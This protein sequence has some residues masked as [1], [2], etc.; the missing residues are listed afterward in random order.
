MFTED[1]AKSAA[2]RESTGGQLQWSVPWALSPDS[3]IWAVKDPVVDRLAEEYVDLQVAHEHQL[4]TALEKLVDTMAGLPEVATQRPPQVLG[5]LEQADGT[6]AARV[7][8]ALE[9]A[10][11]STADARASSAI[12]TADGSFV[13]TVPLVAR[14]SDT[15]V[16]L[17]VTSGTGVLRV[18]DA[19][20]EIRPSGVLPTTRLDGAA[21]PLPTDLVAA[22]QQV[23]DAAPTA[24]PVEPHSTPTIAVGEDECQLVFRKDS[25]SDRFP[26]GVLFRLTDPALSQPSMRYHLPHRDRDERGASLSYYG[27]FS[28]AARVA[29]AVSKLRFQLA[30]RVPVDRP[31]DI[32]A[33]REGLAVER[34]WGGIPVAGSLSIGYVVQMAQRWTPLGLALGDLVYSLPLAPGEQQRIAVTERTSTSSVLESERVDSSEQ[35]SFAERDDTSATSTF[36]S[37]FNEVASGGSHYDTE[38]SSFSVAAAVGGGGVFPFGC[39]AGGVATSFGTSSSAGN[40]NTWM[41]GARNSTS[42]AA[43]ATHSSVQ[44]Q[45]A[46]RRSSSRTAMRLATA[47]ESTEVVT[48]VITNHNKTRALTMQYWEVQ[49]LFDISTVVEGVN[50]VCLVPL[51]VVTFLPP[52]EPPRLTDAPSTRDQVLDRYGRMLTHAD[53]LTRVIPARHRRGLTLL[54]DFAANPSTA[55]ADEA[56]PTSEVLSLSL[57]GTFLK[58]DEVSVTVLGARGIQVGPVRLEGSPS[59][60]PPTGAAAFASEEKLFGALRDARRNTSASQVWSAS[61]ALPPSMARQDVIGFR[62]T[63]RSARLDYTFAPPLVADLGIAG[64][65]LGP[66]GTIGESVLKAALEKPSVSRSYGADRLEQE[67]GGPLVTAFS[68]TLP[69]ATTGGAIVQ[70]VGQ[71]FSGATELPA[72]GFP[73]AARTIPPVLSYASVLEIE[74]TFQWVVRNT[75]TCSIAVFASL[76]PEERAVLLERYEIPMPPDT[77]GNPQPGVPLISCITNNV[78]GYF[79]NCMVLPFMIPA[80][81]TMATGLTTAQVQDALTRFHTDGFDPPRSTI[82]LPTKGVLGEAVLG[83]CPSAEKIDLTRFWNWQD[84]PGDSAPEIAAVAPPGQ[85]IS[86]A[87]TA[88]NTLTGLTPQIQNFAFTPVSAATDLAQALV[89]A[90][91]EQKGF[92]VGALTNTAGLTTLGGKTIDTAESARKDALASATQLAVK[93][94]ETSASIYNG[95]AKDAGG[96]GKGGGGKGDTP[97]DTPPEEPPPPDNPPE[98]TPA[99]PQ[100]ASIHFALDNHDLTVAPASTELAALDATVDEAKTA[101]VKSAVVRGYASPEGT[102]THNVQLAHD[103]ADAVI[104]HLTSKGVTATRAEGGVLAGQPGDYPQLRRADVA[105]Q[106]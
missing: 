8:V 103:R 6:P 37:A 17:V 13:L 98:P 5:R 63:R 28:P 100:T 25:S 76:T 33:F 22:L 49:R 16:A 14:H 15:A 23:T 52:G 55:V 93:A 32:E 51:E 26:Y 101:K 68:A 7:Q 39:V 24:G 12:T 1:F 104:A 86:G 21:G 74:K 82:A 47:T 90:A 61:L 42:N 45:A 96:K 85:S 81:M 30:E 99:P 57:T 84:S 58:G 89:K 35:V 75:M 40:T 38:A 31:L 18:E 92:D 106:Y 50:L 73:V 78:L 43:Q 69:P 46:A 48:K 67:V 95:G 88:P 9:V 66:L 94:M 10:G 105:F 62:I 11:M 54:T 77:K 41:S 3:P 97:S 79:G 102:A 71:G 72:S 87:L 83:H 27:P 34:P 20:A 56:A 64:A 2:A 65:V 4:V 60:T 29:G 44:R 19:L 91:S 70:V 53:V 59:Y 36:A 80:E